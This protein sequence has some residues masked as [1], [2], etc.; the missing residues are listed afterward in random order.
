M[1]S[2]LYCMVS[3][4]TVSMVRRQRVPGL[5]SAPSTE[6]MSWFT[7]CYCIISREIGNL[8][9]CPIFCLKQF[10]QKYASKY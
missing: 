5:N 2:G 9:L 1:V 6:G 10:L 8:F 4:L 7:V 3:Q